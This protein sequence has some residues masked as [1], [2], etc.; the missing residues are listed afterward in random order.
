MTNERLSYIVLNFTESSGM[1]DVNARDITKTFYVFKEVRT[2]ALHYNTLPHFITTSKM[3]TLGSN[4]TLFPS[5]I[6]TIIN[7]N[8][9]II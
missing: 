1:N 9:K 8:C 5:Y 6:R 7:F 3:S 4:Q 2:G